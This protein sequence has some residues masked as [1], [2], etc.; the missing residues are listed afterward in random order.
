MSNA[1]NSRKRAKSGLDFLFVLFTVKR[2]KEKNI[3][4][5]T[6]ILLIEFNSCISVI[7]IACLVKGLIL[8]RRD[9]DHKRTARKSTLF[10]LRNLIVE[11]LRLN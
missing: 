10:Q 7:C 1:T 9:F 5:N 2:K 3:K 11:A 6:I 8:L 4:R